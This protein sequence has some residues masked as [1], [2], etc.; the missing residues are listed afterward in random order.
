[1]TGH[2]PGALALGGG[3]VFGFWFWFGFGSG[4]GFG[5]GGEDFMSGGSAFASASFMLEFLA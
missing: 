5:F 1:L 3:V 4:F 2:Q